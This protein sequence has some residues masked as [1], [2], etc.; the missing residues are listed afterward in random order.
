MMAFSF[1]LFYT[2]NFDVTAVKMI[3]AM[4]MIQTNHR[5][6]CTQSQDSISPFGMDCFRHALDLPEGS[7]Q[8]FIHSISHQRCSTVHHA[9]HISGTP[10]RLCFVVSARTESRLPRSVE[11]S[12]PLERWKGILQNDQ[13][14]SIFH[15][16]PSI[17]SHKR[18]LTGYRWD[19]L[20]LPS[21]PHHQGG[22]ASHCYFGIHS[23]V[24][25]IHRS[26][27]PFII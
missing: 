23:Q 19:P 21:P 9:F 18:R 3:V 11:S 1:T 2:G 15:N 13:S 25:P 17:Q 5:N 7:N 10:Q 26:S 20:W 24:S 8:F 22:K 14:V 16:L 6:D 12:W 4:K 27:R